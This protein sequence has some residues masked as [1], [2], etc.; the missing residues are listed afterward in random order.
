MNIPYMGEML[1]LVTAIIWAFAVI[2]FKKSGESV[3]PVALN[4]FKN[5]L[6]V[7]LFIPTI[8][9]FGE[10]LFYNAPLNDYLLLLFS[11]ALG[12]GLADTLFFK[13]LNI[14]GAGLSAIVDCFYSTFVIILSFAFLSESMGIFQ[15]MGALMIISAVLMAASKKG[16]AHLTR[17]SLFIGILLGALAMLTTAVGL[18][19]IKSLLERSPLFWVVEMRLIGGMTV[20]ALSLLF[21]R[22]RISVLSTLRGNGGWKYTISG[23]FVGA[24]LAMVFWLAGMKYTQA[25]IA[26]ALNQT[27]TV[28]IFIF[29]ALFLKEPINKVRVIGIVLAIAGSMLVTFS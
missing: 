26:A 20:L 6:A 18:V 25:S 23:S 7:V 10:T 15:I 5:T 8:Y 4:L 3:H 1:A 28:F 27:T 12:I 19:M 11:G 24:Y 21:R 16:S 17:K 9:I 13:S 22:D 14:L 29:A 2:L